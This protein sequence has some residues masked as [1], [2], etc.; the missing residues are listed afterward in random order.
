MAHDD[1]EDGTYNDPTLKMLDTLPPW[2]A[3][4]EGTPNEDLIEPV[5]SELREIKADLN[6]I[7]RASM[8][9]NADTIEQ[10]SDIA[11]LVDITPNVGESIGHFRA[12]IIAE[13][14]IVT[15][16][17]TISDL[18]TGLAVILDVDVTRIGPYSEYSEGGR[19]SVTVPQGSLDNTD[20]TDTEIATLGQKI[21]AA[22]Y[23]LDTTVKGSLKFVSVETYN[24]VTDGSDSWNNY[25]G[26]DGLDSNG[27]PKGNGGTFAG[28]VGGS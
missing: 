18:L 26:Y 7:E 21:L 14:Q 16:K 10:L 5:G 1:D 6:D 24:D 3:N 17:G 28:V 19:A 2:Y 20:L 22:S 12:R 13:L 25:P 23:G 4:G 15:A 8:P 27:D 11:S 9:Q